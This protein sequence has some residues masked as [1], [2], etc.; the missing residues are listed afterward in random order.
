MPDQGSVSL[1]EDAR[2][3]VI[4]ACGIPA[5][6][7]SAADGTGARE[8]Y[9]RFLWGTLAP[10]GKMAAAELADKLDVSDLTLDF[11]ELQ[12]SDVAG[13][14]RAFQSLVGAGMDLAAAA[15]VTGLM[16][17]AAA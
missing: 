12:A 15:A 4:T 7:V 16:T 9:R 10:L 17:D 1:L 5:E 11:S 13:R 14:A 3:A 8:A 2:L 6:L